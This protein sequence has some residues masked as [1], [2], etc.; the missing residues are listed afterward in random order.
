MRNNALAICSVQTH[1]PMEP[2]PP[3]WQVVGPSLPL[4]TQI[5]PSRPGLWELG[6]VE[7]KRQHPGSPLILLEGK[8]RPRDM[9]VIEEV[10]P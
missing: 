5:S 9:P 8:L 3:K 7:V 4:K 1:L 10:V 6:R 2:T